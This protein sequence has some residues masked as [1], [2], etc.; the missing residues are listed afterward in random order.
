MNGPSELPESRSA[1]KRGKVRENFSAR[2]CHIEWQGREALDE[3]EYRC[4]WLMLLFIWTYPVEKAHLGD[5]SNQKKCSFSSLFCAILTISLLPSLS[6]FLF[7]FP[8]SE[9]GEFLD[10]LLTTITRRWKRSHHRNWQE[11]FS[12]VTTIIMIS[13]QQLNVLLYYR[14]H[15]FSLLVITNK[16]SHE[17]D[18]VRTQIVSDIKEEKNDKVFSLLHTLDGN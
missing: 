14:K 7:F 6:L 12:H 18:D 9:A 11:L 17:T 5:Q 8:P 13:S 1:E 4:A 16:K 10:G 3:Y 15:F 2:R